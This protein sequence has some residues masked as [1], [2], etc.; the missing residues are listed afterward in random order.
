LEFL[1]DLQIKAKEAIQDDLARHPYLTAGALLAGA[2]AISV[3]A[4]PYAK[5]IITGLKDEF[6]I[7][8]LYL[9]SRYAAVHMQRQQ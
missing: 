6:A 7:E 4:R 8:V 5:S 3:V 2:A 9:L 1:H